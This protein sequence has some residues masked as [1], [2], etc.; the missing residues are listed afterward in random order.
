MNDAFPP[1]HGKKERLP[2]HGQP[3]FIIYE[4]Q[5]LFS[6]NLKFNIHL[7]ITVQFDHSLVA[8]CLLDGVFAK[9][10]VFAVNLIPLCIEGFSKLN[11]ID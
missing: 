8:S 10:D 4:C 11:G 3:L 7:Y 5:T 9:D 1:E 6:H 2:D